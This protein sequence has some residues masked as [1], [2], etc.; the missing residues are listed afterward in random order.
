MPQSPQPGPH[1]PWR[2]LFDLRRASARINLFFALVV[3]AGLVAG[4]G[5]LAFYTATHAAVR[6]GRELAGGQAKLVVAVAVAGG[7]M[8]GLLGAV[9]PKSRLE[10]VARVIYGAALGRAL[11]GPWEALWVFIRSAITIGTGGSAG[12]EGPVVVIGAGLAGT[13]GRWAR[14]SA[15]EMRTLLAAGVAA[16]V[17]VAFNAPVAGSL[18]ALEIILGDFAAGTFS[19]VVLAAVAATV[20]TYGVLGSQPVLQVPSYTF[21]HWAELFLYAGLG[22]AAGLMGRLYIRAIR[23]SGR[24]F[25][26]L[27][28]PAWIR[29]AVGGLLFG[30]VGALQPLTLGGA[31]TPI[32]VAAQGGL[33]WQVLLGL[34]LIKLVTTAITLGS[35]GAGGA[36]APGFV[37]GAFLGGGYGTLM[38]QLFPTITGAVGGYALVGLGAMLAS[39]TLAPITAILLLFEITRDYA[40]ILPAMVACATAYRVSRTFGP[41]TIDTLSLHEAGIEWRS[42]RQIGLLQ[43]VTADQVMT[44]AVHTVRADQTVA[45]VIALMQRYRHTGYPVVDGKGRLVGMVTLEDVRETPLE[46]R[47]QRPVAEVMSSRPIVS[48][49]DETLDQVLRTL[50]G[51][52]VGRVAVVDRA[53][54]GRLLGIIT[55][56]D[57]LRAYNERAVEA[58]RKPAPVKAD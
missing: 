24:L 51:Q 26:R 32:T 39:F 45:D 28:G 9:G 40:I 30:V 15:R 34:A 11:V 38:H 53:D 18:F 16:G 5:S 13:L 21:H 20:L 22:V 37:I 1:R 58:Q 57:V 50:A 35:G 41:Y 17:A 7:L 43:R 31:Y 10:G 29:P 2:E 49:A 4:L 55:K 23:G 3:V 52:G 44:R 25:Q 8:V 27:P 54:P 56:S 33:A 42:G 6:L 19:L 36:F 47:L 14:L 48:Y 46:G 12:R